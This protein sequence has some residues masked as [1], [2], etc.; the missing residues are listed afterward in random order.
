ME[1][2]FWFWGLGVFGWRT[3]VYFIEVFEVLELE[4]VTVEF[5]LRKSCCFNLY[6]KF[7]VNIMYGGFD[8]MKF[9]R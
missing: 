8:G 1:V 4:V 7:V 9:S 2:E 6:V 5:E 3:I